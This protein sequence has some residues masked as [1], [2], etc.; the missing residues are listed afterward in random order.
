MTS[1]KGSPLSCLTGGV[2]GMTIFETNQIAGLTLLQTST[3]SAIQMQ[4]KCRVSGPS[5]RG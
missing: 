5:I 2:G 3:F 4:L 1:R